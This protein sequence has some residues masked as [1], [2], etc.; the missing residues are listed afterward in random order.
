MK[1]QV[2]VLFS[3]LIFASACSRKVT[4]AGK[5]SY[6]ADK[7]HGRKTASGATFS[8]SKLTAAHKS[9]PFGTKV[10]VVNRDNGRTV[11]VRIN[12]RGPFVA[13]RIIDLSKKAAKKIGLIQAGVANVEIKYK[14]KKR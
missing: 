1:I 12:D 13:G 2:L 8:Q 7:F 3:I 4:E 11:K 14:K 10:K 5:A 9:L 6:Y